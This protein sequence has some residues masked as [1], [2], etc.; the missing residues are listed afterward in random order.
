MNAL[1]LG[2]GYVGSS[3]ATC[4][5]KLGLNLTVTTTTPERIPTLEQM[6]NHAIVIKGND[7][8]GLKALLA[9]QDIVL[10]SIAL[11]KSSNYQET[12]L[13]TAQT[14]A[15]I[16]P[17]ITTVKQLIYTSSY[18]V[19]GDQQGNLVDE[20]TP[21]K[22]ANP[23]DEIFAQTEQT[24]L[25][26]AN[27]N[28]KVCIFRLG[29]IYGPGRELFKIFERLAAALRVGDGNDAINWVHL[30]DIVGAIELARHQQLDGIYNLVDDAKLTSKELLKG[31]CEQHNLP[32]VIWDESSTGIRP[33]NAR[34][35]NQKI[36]DAGYNLQHPLI[37]DN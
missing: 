27:P 3:V 21:L 16:L 23:K 25:S 29:G 30:D 1:I 11:K 2:C 17:E 14:L 5:Q 12:Y 10:L 8:E 32:P 18:S 33:Y 20:N 13:E 9:N 37:I 15:E 19:Y 36:K 34:V 24:L 28:L 22:P 26:I 6:A 4:W 35:S 31:I 7:K